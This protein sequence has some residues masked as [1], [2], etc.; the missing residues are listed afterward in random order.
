MLVIN[1]FMLFV[2]LCVAIAFAKPAPDPQ[3][4]A[5]FADS[6]TS[7]TIVSPWGGNLGGSWTNPYGS[8]TNSYSGYG[9]YSNAAG[10]L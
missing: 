6:M 5:G 9:R 1:K 8:F 3:I 2:L 7:G 4:V 10:F